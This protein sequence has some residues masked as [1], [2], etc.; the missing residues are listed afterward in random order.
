V[1]PHEPARDRASNYAILL[2]H[3]LVDEQGDEL[4]LLP[5]VPDGWLDEGRTITVQ[6]LPTH[7]GELA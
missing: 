2:R 5:A 7:F 3:M 6:R 4:H 1:E